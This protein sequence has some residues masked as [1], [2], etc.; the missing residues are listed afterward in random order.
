MPE[1]YFDEAEHHVQRAALAHR[2][3]WRSL[4]NIQAGTPDEK[5]RHH[6]V[7]RMW[8]RNWADPISERLEMIKVQEPSSFGARPLSVMVVND[9]YRA[10]TEASPGYDMGPEEAFSRIEGAAA[11]AM[12]AV[13]AGETLTDEQRY[14]LALI[15]AL[16][17]VRVPEVIAMAI[18]EDPSGMKAGI[19]AF[20]A[21][22]L[23]E[24]DGPSPP[25]FDRV[26]RGRSSHELAQFMLEGFPEFSA[27]E[28]G[29]SFW[30]LLDAAHHL[31]G[32]IYRRQWTLFT[33]KS[34]LL[35]GDDPVSTAPLGGVTFKA[36][37]CTMVVDTPVPIGPHTL[38]LIGNRSDG[39]GAIGAE[40][41]EGY[42]GISNEI[43]IHRAKRFLVGP[44]IG[45]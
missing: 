26:A 24:P 15:V 19:E 35:L 10:G 42:A 30:N 43:Q 17:H 31:A 13:L 4:E 9:L 34:I 2:D 25:E 28:R 14:D 12:S 41:G 11:A 40:R 1:P 3:R 37:G 23:A 32:R 27:I 36:D 39:A 21:A 44:P 38:L 7:P 22:M 5:R 18:V 29:F 33:T 6:F 20:A 8:L 16:Q 45:S